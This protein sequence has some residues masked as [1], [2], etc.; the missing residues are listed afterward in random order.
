[1]VVLHGI[2]PHGWS[3]GVM[4]YG[5]RRVISWYGI[6]VHYPYCVDVWAI[7]RGCG[8]HG[9]MG[10]ATCPFCA[11]G[12]WCYVMNRPMRRFALHVNVTLVRVDVICPSC[13]VSIVR[14]LCRT[15]TNVPFRRRPQSRERNT[16]FCISGQ[17]VHHVLTV[18]TCRSIVS[19]TTP[20]VQMVRLWRVVRHVVRQ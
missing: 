5:I 9:K 2:S 6:I 7:V 18:T 8:A 1:M 19:C 11:P 14:P 16:P 13:F 12:L 3:C 4:A 17:Y 15:A 20:T 10:M